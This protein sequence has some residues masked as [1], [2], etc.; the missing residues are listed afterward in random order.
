MEQNQEIE[1]KKGNKVYIPLAIIL[2]AVIVSAVIWYRNYSK[3][4]STDDAL[5]DSDRVAVGSKVMGRISN[6]YVEEGDSVKKGMLL[7]ELDSTEMVAQKLQLVSLKNQAITTKQQMEAK[8]LYDQQSIKV[9]EINFQKA[10]DDLNR[11]KTQ[12]EGGVLTKENY[13]HVQKAFESAKATYDA[14]KTALNVSKAQIATTQA[15][16]ESCDAQIGVSAAQ[17]K[18]TKLYAPINGV[19]AKRWLLPGDIAQPGQSILTITNDQKFWVSVYIEET[20]LRGIYNG[21]SAKFFVDAFPDATFFGKVYSISSNTA[22][23]F[24]L[25]PPSNASG[26]F[27]KITQRVPLKIS[28][29]TIDNQGKKPV[30]LLSGMS[31]VVKIIK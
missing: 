31:V 26:N 14:A 10:S 5:V 29:D 4:I 6:I 23:Q 25:I 17:L 27:T 24:S 28:I 19:V 15:S 12:F 11:A 8:Y 21:Q 7:A 9:Q 18:N 13:E 3:Y 2:L 22:A 20:K 16:I 1:K 30:K